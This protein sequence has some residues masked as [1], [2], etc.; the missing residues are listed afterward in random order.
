[1]KLGLGLYRYA[2]TRDDFQFARQAGA[3][4]IVAHLVDYFQ[5]EADHPRDNQPAGTDQGWGLACKSAYL[6]SPNLTFSGT[7][8]SSRT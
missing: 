8:G 3:T 1:M 4:H 7:A 2:L 6:M 5:S